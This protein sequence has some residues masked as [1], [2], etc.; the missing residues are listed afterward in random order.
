[1]VSNVWLRSKIT[2]R[3]FVFSLYFSTFVSIFNLLSK[4][5]GN[6]LFFGFKTQQLDF[7]VKIYCKF[8]CIYLHL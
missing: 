4:F 6:V 5:G 1:M 7:W 3:Y 2:P 8:I